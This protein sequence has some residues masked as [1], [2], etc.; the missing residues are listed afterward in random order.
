MR[1][2]RVLFVIT[3]FV[4]AV[5]SLG[6][7]TYASNGI[8]PEEAAKKDKTEKFA[9]MKKNLNI[10]ALEITDNHNINQQQAISIAKTLPFSSANAK[11]I[12]AYQAMITSQN[13]KTQG[14]SPD[15]LKANPKIKEKDYVSEIPV[16]IIT[17]KGVNDIG[18]HG[19]VFPDN[20][21]VI[22]A[23]TG[24]FLFGFH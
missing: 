14:L 21:V 11:E 3:M 9:Q 1:K 6:I 20:N 2:K 24:Q 19:A 12:K 17:F 5:M 23:T 10:D 4:I 8:S 13:I 22:D 15:A 18:S 7:V 16:W